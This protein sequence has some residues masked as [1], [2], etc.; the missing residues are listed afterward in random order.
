[1]KAVGLGKRYERKM[2]LSTGQGL[3][4]SEKMGKAFLTIDFS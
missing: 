1:V 2:V 4:K 3:G